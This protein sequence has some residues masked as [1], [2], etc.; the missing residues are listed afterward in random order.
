MRGRED[1]R[2]RTHEKV[3]VSPPGQRVRCTQCVGKRASAY[4]RLTLTACSTMLESCLLP[5]QSTIV[6][7]LL[8]LVPGT[9]PS[10]FTHVDDAGPCVVLSREVQDAQLVAAQEL[11]RGARKEDAR[12]SERS[13]RIGGRERGGTNALLTHTEMKKHSHP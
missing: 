6:V 3:R 5:D 11:Q 13:G 8:P 10:G 12:A 4:S 9:V 2:M 7:L 1:E